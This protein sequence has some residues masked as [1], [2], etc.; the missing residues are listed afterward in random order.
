MPVSVLGCEMLIGTLATRLFGN[1][2]AMQQMTQMIIVI[3]RCDRVLMLRFMVL[4]S[5]K[6]CNVSTLK[7]D[8]STPFQSK[9]MVG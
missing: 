3:T 9:S 5:A 4:L 6:H 2:A 8:S 7:V 1:S